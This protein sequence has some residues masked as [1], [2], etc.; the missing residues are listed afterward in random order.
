M[1][2]GK[3]E[4]FINDR[5]PNLRAA[6]WAVNAHAER[7]NV[8]SGEYADMQDYIS[9]FRHMVWLAAID[10]CVFLYRYPRYYRRGIATGYEF[11]GICFPYRNGYK[12]FTVKEEYHA[13]EMLLSCNR[14]GFRTVYMCDWPFNMLAS[15]DIK[16]L[17][18]PF[19]EAV[20]PRVYNGIFA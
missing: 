8:I 1:G 14:S 18:Y 12:T 5:W 16:A 10:K 4:T 15:G 17:H 2:K 11:T 9:A 3:L 19:K 20:K 6:M 13:G 7:Y